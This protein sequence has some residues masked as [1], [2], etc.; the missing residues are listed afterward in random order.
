MN[1][2]LSKNIENSVINISKDFLDKV[3]EIHKTATEFSVSFLPKETGEHVLNMNKELL[4][5]VKS[6]ID[7]RIDDMKKR[8]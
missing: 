7:K 3:S 8:A 4:L 6:I 5:A 2:D 1:E